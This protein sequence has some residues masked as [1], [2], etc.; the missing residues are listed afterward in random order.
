MVAQDLVDAIIMRP[1]LHISKVD[2]NTKLK[3]TYEYDP[4]MNLYFCRDQMITTSKG[5]VLCNM[6]SKQRSPEVQIIKFVLN[7]MKIKPI[8]EVKENGKLEGGTLFTFF[9]LF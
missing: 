8:Y 1:T 2:K 9:P 4:L 3:A 5:V 7:K 6:N